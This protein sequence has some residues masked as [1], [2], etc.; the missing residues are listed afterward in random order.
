MGHLLIRTVRLK[1]SNFSNKVIRHLAA[2]KRQGVILDM[3]D[4]IFPERLYVLSFLDLIFDPL[5]SELGRKKARMFQHAFIEFWDNGARKNIFQFFIEDY[6]LE[7]LDLVFFKN[8]YSKVIVPGGLEVYTWVE[9]F[10]SVNSLPVA[11]L[12]NGHPST[13]KNKFHQ[14]EPKSLFQNVQ[15]Y[16]ANEYIPKPN[17][18]GLLEISKEWGIPPSTILL[19]GDSPQDRDCA[20]NAGCDFILCG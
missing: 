13:Q 1:D 6:N 5:A 8:A 12:S 9:N 14:L 7:T 4:T 10:L 20:V 2:E 15:L 16:C 17:A 18:M 19:I 3:D 11:I